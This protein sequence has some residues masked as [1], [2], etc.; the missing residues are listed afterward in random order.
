MVHLVI[1]NIKV[2]LPSVELKSC[3]YRV[4]RFGPI[5]FMKAASR[6]VT[7]LKITEITSL[8]KYCTFSLVK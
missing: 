7:L 3:A 2:V 6:E 1:L 5:V 4:H 8:Y